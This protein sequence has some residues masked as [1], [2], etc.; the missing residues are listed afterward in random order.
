MPPRPPLSSSSSSHSAA[1]ASPWDEKQQTLTGP[2]RR[3]SME[4]TQRPSN[5]LQRPLRGHIT[6]HQENTVASSYE[7]GLRNNDY[8]TPSFSKEEDASSSYLYEGYG[9][10]GTYIEEQSPLQREERLVQNNVYLGGKTTLNPN[11]KVDTKSVNVSV[12]AI[13]RGRS[14]PL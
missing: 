13:G 7:G 5:E 10:A 8:P 12:C 1:H 11:G 2:G 14:R 9:G 6:Y 4:S 3:S